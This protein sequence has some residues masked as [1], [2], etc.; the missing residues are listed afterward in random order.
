MIAQEE[1][2][3][4]LSIKLRIT[5]AIGTVPLPSPS[6]LHIL[7]RKR[8]Y[9]LSRFGTNYGRTTLLA[10]RYQ[11]FFIISTS[12][13]V[14]LKL[15][16]LIETAFYGSLFNLFIYYITVYTILKLLVYNHV[17]YTYAWCKWHYHA[18]TFGKHCI[19]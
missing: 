9:Q 8:E 13:G 7:Y 1:C 10:I 5:F 18:D 3:A 6:L 15:Y 12:K 16:V 4:G 14:L 19:A 2:I 11:G 17:L